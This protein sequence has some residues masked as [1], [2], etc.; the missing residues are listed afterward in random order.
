M[1]NSKWGRRI[2]AY[3]K[4]KRIS[5]IEL[6]KELEVAPATLGKIERGVKVPT[7]QQWI[8]MAD[9]LGISIEE[10]KGQEEGEE[11]DT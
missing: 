1:E 6:A 7:E 8:I 5:Q 3:R 4:L 9:V 10:L 2:R 11:I